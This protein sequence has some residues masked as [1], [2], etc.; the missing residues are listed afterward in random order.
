MSPELGLLPITKSPVYSGE[1]PGSSIAS[2]ALPSVTI[3][4]SLAGLLGPEFGQYTMF[5][6]SLISPKSVSGIEDENV[7]ELVL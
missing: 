6:A 5:R 1:F 4:V 3:T 7:P 2:I